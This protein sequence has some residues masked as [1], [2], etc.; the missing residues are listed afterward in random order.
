MVNAWVLKWVNPHVRY[1][2]T[3]EDFH[4]DALTTGQWQYHAISGQVGA[5]KPLFN[6]P[7][8]FV[9]PDTWTAEEAEDFIALTGMK[10]RAVVF[11]NEEWEA[12]LFAAH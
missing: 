3:A 6:G 1:T 10:A 5:T 4:L 11:T 7:G 12:F 9:I 8:K 2:S